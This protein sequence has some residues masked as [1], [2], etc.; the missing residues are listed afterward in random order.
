MGLAQDGPVDSHWPKREDS[1]MHNIVDFRTGPSRSRRSIPISQD[2][3]QILLFTGV[4]YVRDEQAP[5][6]VPDLTP[7]CQESRERAPHEA[8]GAA[9]GASEACLDLAAH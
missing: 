7:F 6:F 8:A 2:G 3:A 1:R 9:P 5:S 4:R